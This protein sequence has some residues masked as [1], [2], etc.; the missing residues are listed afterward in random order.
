MSRWVY[1]IT[2]KRQ[3]RQLLMNGMAEE[4]LTHKQFVRIIGDTYKA[5]DDKWDST[6]LVGDNISTLRTE[7]L[8]KRRIL[9][10]LRR[11]DIQE[12]TNIVI[13]EAEYKAARRKL[14]IAISKAK[15]VAWE[16][17]RRSV[18]ENVYGDGYKRVTKMMGIK[19]PALKLSKED[20]IRGGKI[21]S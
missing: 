14:K 8:S 15:K 16:N 21:V 9:T 19:P 7:A 1:E 17:V 10:R 12:Q 6:L 3:Y 11:R 4:V 2:S 13:A 18:D 5:K 20:K